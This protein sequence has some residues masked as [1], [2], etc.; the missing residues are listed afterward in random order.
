MSIHPQPAYLHQFFEYS[1]ARQP[2]AIA[3]ASLHTQLTYAELEVRANQ[4]AHRL[5]QR[6]VQPG[7]FVGL[8]LPRGQDLYVAMLAILK[9]GAAYV[10]IDPTAPPER[11]QFILEDCQARLVIDEVEDCSALPRHPLSETPGELAYVI[12]TS[13]TTGRPKG[14][15]LEHS[16]V[17]HLVQA[18][19]QL[20]Q[21]R[22][23][24]RIFQFASVTFDASVEEIWMA[25]AH[26]A[27]LVWG[28]QEVVRSG[29]D[30]AH[31]MQELR[32]SV[33]SCVP[34]FLAMV[35]E[36]IA[37]LR[38][39]IL[40]GEACTAQLVERWWRP[41]RTV[42][43]TYGPTEATVIATAC[44]LQPGQPITIGRPIPGY[45]IEL[46]D[47]HL[48]PVSM[49]EIGEIC[50]GGPG[51]ARGYLQ[52]DEL[53]AQKFVLVEGRRYYRSADLGRWNE[54]GDLEYLGRSDAQVKLRGYRVELSE[55]EAVLLECAGIQTAAV[56]VNEETQR[57]AAYCVA[58][59]EHPP[60]LAEVRQKLKDRLPA[61]MVPATL[62]FLIQIPQ[63]VAGKVDRRALPTPNQALF[64]QRELVA[65]TSEAEQQVYEVFRQIFALDEL[66]IYDDFF[67]DL[68][69]HS[70]LVA[71]AISKLRFLPGFSGISVG[72]LYAHPS[73]ASLALLRQAVAVSAEPRAFEP[74]P[75]W[76][77]GWCGLGQAVG[78]IF[79]SGV[80]AWQ[81]LGAFLTYGYLVVTDEWSVWHALLGAVIV[82]VLTTPAILTLSILVKWL[83]LGKIKPGQHPLWGW[84]Y[85]RFWFVRA[86]VRASPV[87]YLSGT[88]WLNWYYRL[89]GARIGTGVFLG[90][91]GLSTFDL[92]EVGDGCSVGA[93]TTLDGVSVEG[94]MLRLGRVT[95]GRNCWLG[96]RSSLGLNSRMEDGAGLDDL[97]MLPDDGVIPAG[98]L[99]RGSPAAPAGTP[100]GRPRLKPWGLALAIGQAVG[101]AA[102]PLMVLAAVFPGLMLITHL[103]HLD[104]GFSFLLAA[105]FVGLT[106]VLCLCTE[107]WVLKWLLLGRIRPGCRPIKSWFY[108]RV[109]LFEKVM[110]MSLEVVGTLYTTLYVAP[111]I[112][113]LGGK[114]G[115]RSEISTIRFVQPDLVEAEAECFF[116]DDVSVG[117]ADI[118]DGWI[119]HQMTT[120][121]SRTF[122]G[123]G[124]VIPAGSVLGSE[125]LIG[126]MSR[127]P[128]EVP[129]GTSWFGSPAQRLVAR[130][131]PR[132]QG[133]GVTYRPS[134]SLVW[135]RLTW[136]LLR[137]V[138]PS[139]LFVV[140]ASLI[141]NVTDYLQDHISHGEWL[142]L[143][144]FLYITAG[145]LAISLSVAAKWL[146]VGV[147][148]AEERPL[149][150]SFVWR[151]E[152]VTGLYENFGVMFF[153]ELLRATVFLPWVLR[154]FGM[155]IG[156]QCY[157]DSTWFTEFDLITLGNQVAL[158]ENANLQTHL[159]QDRV[160]ACGEL[161][162]GDRTVVG[163]MSTVLYQS[164]LHE[165]S[166]L[167]DLSLVMKGEQLPA[168]TQWHGA[169]AIHL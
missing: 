20:Y 158:N 166:R 5:R 130:Q 49:G 46:M 87:Q 101:I 155:K 135:Q 41:E 85:W 80:Y 118:R 76:R 160:M 31:T 14:C 152:L 58:A 98:Q 11:R 78:L 143:L 137:I 128:L 112:A 124:A 169:P 37:C 153:I 113:S 91:H 2:E 134:S 122:I 56:G 146:L 136:E 127:S 95:L 54:S 9:A 103:G 147:Y 150:C 50:I 39:L 75:W 88:P 62:D 119:T 35:E 168:Q 126:A 111:W 159:F 89:M 73:V 1:A 133:E 102:F 68:G 52:R 108:L 34:T 69:G 145:L 148:R 25:F 86:L 61:Y 105:P 51:V 94:G 47:E 165:G 70:L 27:T 149:W 16:N 77:H 141:M 18:E 90:A 6:G 140:L 48:K 110:E 23:E 156:A 131:K 162:L 17:V 132:D 123:N 44:A 121:G 19:H 138:L 29:L 120:F 21:I 55:V 125:V 164:E 30:F 65:P 42:W 33:L 8:M 115:P 24:D 3:L 45:Q 32:V 22:Q 7:D 66:S 144:P 104:Q 82:N 81:W 96:N 63:T 67:Q 117:A 59:R 129:G 13:G 4:W 53:T 142:V 43:N 15:L 99:W 157:I 74:C 72:D 92:L 83:L 60:D 64:G 109:W 84:Y 161:N 38:I 139:T 12:Y 154:A 151:S 106:F 93:D 167:G 107:I 114:I 116:A 79:L 36:D 100:D 97:S 26:G 40:G 71:Q 163:S 28:P 57:L 10:P